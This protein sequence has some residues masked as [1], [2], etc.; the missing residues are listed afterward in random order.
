MMPDGIVQLEWAVT[1]EEINT[2]R[3]VPQD[4]IHEHCTLESDGWF[5]FHVF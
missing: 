3:A 1:T 5:L 2:H 4:E